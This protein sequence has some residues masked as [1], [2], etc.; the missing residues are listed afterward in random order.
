MRLVT[1]RFYYN[2]VYRKYLLLKASIGRYQARVF[3]DFDD[4]LV[5]AFQMS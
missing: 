3:W 5:D 4:Y 1:D 2:L